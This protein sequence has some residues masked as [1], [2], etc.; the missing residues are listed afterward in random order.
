VV[1]SKQ[2]S[3]ALTSFKPSTTLSSRCLTLSSRVEIWDGPGEYVSFDLSCDSSDLLCIQICFQAGKGLG[4]QAKSTR[5]DTKGKMLVFIFC[6]RS[7]D[8]SRVHSDMMSLGD[9]EVVRFYL[10]LHEFPRNIWPQVP[11]VV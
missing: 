10:L 2:S 6:K 4:F 5:N 8:Q 1:R 11:Q 3:Q 7:Y 9:K